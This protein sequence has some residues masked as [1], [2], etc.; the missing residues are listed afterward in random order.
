MV[1][2]ETLQVS[3]YLLKNSFIYSGEVSNIRDTFM[4]ILRTDHDRCR[5][6]QRKCHQANPPSGVSSQCGVDTKRKTWEKSRV[7]KLYRGNERYRLHISQ[8]DSIVSSDINTVNGQRSIMQNNTLLCLNI[9]YLYEQH[10]KRQLLRNL[11]RLQ[12]VRLKFLVTKKININLK[13]IK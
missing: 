3:C 1:Q 2:N 13:I 7:T 5:F 10:T 8:R 12:I 6:S 11:H 9:M 4:T